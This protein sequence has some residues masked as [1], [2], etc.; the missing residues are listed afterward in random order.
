MRWKWIVTCLSVLV[1]AYFVTGIVVWK[2]AFPDYIHS[3]YAERF[4]EKGL[5]LILLVNV[6]PFPTFLQMPGCLYDVMIKRPDED[7]Y[8]KLALGYFGRGKLGIDGCSPGHVIEPSIHVLHVGNGT[9]FVSV[10]RDKQYHFDESVL[11]LY[12]LTNDGKDSIMETSLAIKK[13]DSTEDTYCKISVR[14]L[15]SHYSWFEASEDSVKNLVANYF[16]DSDRVEAIYDVF[17]QLNLKPNC[18]DALTEAIKD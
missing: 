11:D 2:N 16:S 6:D 17:R 1:L 5:D 7:A 13:D 14:D 10:F 8:R 9:R 15:R 18:L 4:S 12:T 3:E